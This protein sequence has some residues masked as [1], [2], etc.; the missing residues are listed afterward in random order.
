MR[1][2]AKEDREALDFCFIFDR[3]DRTPEKIGKPGVEL[4]LT[5]YGMKNESFYP[6]SS[7]WNMKCKW[8]YVYVMHD[9]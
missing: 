9:M 6:I 7:Q 4:F 3:T 2:I 5:R 1:L 8:V